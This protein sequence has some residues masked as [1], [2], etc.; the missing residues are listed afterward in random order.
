MQQHDR[1]VVHVNDLGFGGDRL[2]D[3]MHVFPGGKAD[4]DVQELPDARL[5]GEE[6]HGPP[7]E[8]PCGAGGLR[9]LGEG[10]NRGV[11]RDPVDLVIVL[12]AEKVVIY[13]R[14]M[15]DVRFD[16]A[17]FPPIRSGTAEGLICHGPSIRDRRRIKGRPGP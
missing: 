5:S 1:V 4:A 2:R 6:P 12:A 16:P 8:R 17:G 15:R 7:Q 13:P 11:G 14:R 3:L 10:L 9:R